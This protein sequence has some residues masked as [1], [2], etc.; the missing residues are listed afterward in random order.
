MAGGHRQKCSAGVGHIVEIAGRRERPEANPALAGSD[1]A[2]DRGDHSTGTLAGTVGVER[3]EHGHR[4]FKAAPVAQSDLIGA[5]LAG[6]VGRLAHQGMV[7]GDWHKLGGAI[8]FGGGGVHHPLHPEVPGRLDHIEGSVD[9]GVDI[10]GRRYVAVGNSNQ[11]GQ[12]E[13]LL[14]APH[15]F[16]HAEGIPNIAKHHVKLGLQGR[17]QAVEPAPATLGVVEAEGAHLMTRCQQCFHQVGAY[18]AV[19][20]SNQ[21][22]T[23]LKSPE[24]CKRVSAQSHSRGVSISTERSGGMR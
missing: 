6:G 16:P 17:R 5:D 1:L 8:G 15:R 10:T 11:G 13:H 3:T 20:P 24:C 7:F 21:N 18:K 9:V 2:D 22:S 4:R 14:A 12:V 19:G 23:H